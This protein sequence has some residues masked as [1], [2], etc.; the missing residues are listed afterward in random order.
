MNMSVTDAKVRR[1]GAIVLLAGAA[2]LGFFVGGSAWIAAAAMAVV[3][4]I[5][6]VTAQVRTCS[7]YMPFR[8]STNK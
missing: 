3:A 4:V 6:I 7:L 1:V 5:F 2:L 8:F